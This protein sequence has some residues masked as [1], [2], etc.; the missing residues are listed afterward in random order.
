MKKL[1]RVTTKDRKKIIRLLN[2]KLKYNAKVLKNYEESNERLKSENQKLKMVIS[3]YY[4]YL[5]MKH[6]DN[7]KD[8]KMLKETIK[9]LYGSDTSWL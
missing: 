7:D 8:K 4:S 2:M 3:F 9:R 5:C 1:R 6:S